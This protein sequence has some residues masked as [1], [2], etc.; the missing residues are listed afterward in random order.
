MHELL[1]SNKVENKLEGIQGKYDYLKASNSVKNG[2]CLVM[3]GNLIYS[4]GGSFGA[5]NNIMEVY[6]ITTDTWSAV[7]FNNAAPAGRHSPGFCLLDDK[8]YMFGGSLGTSW[9]PMSNEAWCY[10]FATKLWTKLANY[11]VALALVSAVA[12][13]GKIYLFGGFTGSGPSSPFHEYNPVANTY[14]NINHS[15]A[16]RYAHRAV[17]INDQMYIF[18]GSVGSTAVKES[19]K[20]DPST[21]TWTSLMPPPEARP[22]AYAVAIGTLV[23]IYGGRQG[24][25]SIAIK[26]LYRFNAITNSWIEMPIGPSLYYLGGAVANTNAIF[27]HGGMDETTLNSTGQMLRIT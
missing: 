22:H 11:P 5:P 20:Y 1:L 19:W 13:K 8:L 17:A 25:E 3:I 16:S 4:Y 21:N 10:D 26:K 9:G 27:L 2:H 18:G 7:T 14:R 12:I 23:Y 24:N 6:D 15:L